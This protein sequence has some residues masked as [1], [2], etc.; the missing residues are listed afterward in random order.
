MLRRDTLALTALLALLTAVGPISVDMYLPSLPDISRAFGAPVPQV[1]LTL[2]GFLLCFAI[3]QIVYGPVSDHIG[4]R[5]VLQASLAIYG[6]ASIGC[7]LAPS[8]ET[9]VLLR[10]VQAFGVAAAPVLAR[11]IVRDLYTGVRAGRE[12][13]R[14]GT[15][16]A[17]APAVAP[18]LGGLLQTFMGWQANFYVMAVFGLYAFAMVTWKL[19]ETLER[20]A[21]ATIS[22]SSILRRYGEFLRHRGFLSYLAILSA[23]YGGLFAWISGSSFA[24]QTLYG[25]SAFAF[26]LTFAGSTLGFLCGTLIAAKLVGR[27]GLD[28]TI[29]W[30]GVG[31]AAGGVAMLIATALDLRSPLAL[32]LPIALYLVGLGMA[33]PQS[34]AG[35]LTPFSDRAG[36][37]SSVLGFVQQVVASAIGIAVG[38]SLSQSALPLAATIA[39]LGALA[40]ALAVFNWIWRTR[41][42]AQ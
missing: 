16:M 15:I 34:I 8:V 19:P 9:L 33:Y 37:A 29:V 13:S 32:A 22:L 41:S 39:A 42:G 18:S 23:G 20:P 31:L 5:P 26:G 24:L 7:A 38:H 11:A 30:G 10:G 2:S 17:L 40:L 14:M 36:A 4:R 28:R 12:L 21:H 35:A 25:Q 1:Q 3:G 6:A 27:L